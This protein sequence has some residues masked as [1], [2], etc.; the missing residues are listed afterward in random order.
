MARLRAYK[1]MCERFLTLPIIEVRRHA[2]DSHLDGFIH[3]RPIDILAG[4][5]FRNAGYRIFTKNLSTT[6]DVQ[7]CLS[8]YGLGYATAFIIVIYLSH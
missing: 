8:G 1:K 5:S 6:I 7:G 4:E 3:A 2:I